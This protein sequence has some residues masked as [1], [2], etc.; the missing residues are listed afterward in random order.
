MEKTQLET[1]RDKLL[2]DGEVSRNW[3]LR[4]HITRLSAHMLELKKEGLSTLP[5]YRGGDYVYVL[6][7]LGESGSVNKIL[8]KWRKD[9]KDKIEQQSAEDIRTPHLPGLQ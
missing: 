5:F 7:K 3:C 8:D 1:V 9:G 4:Q 6:K 2:L